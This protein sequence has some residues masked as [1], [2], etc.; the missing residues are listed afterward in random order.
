MILANLELKAAINRNGLHVSE[1]IGIFMNQVRETQHMTGFGTMK[2]RYTLWRF[3]IQP[4]FQDAIETSKT[5]RKEYTYAEI[6]SLLS[7]YIIAN[8]HV[9]YDERNSRIIHSKG[10]K[11]GVAFRVNS[12]HGSQV[13]HLIETQLLP[14]TLKE[15]AAH[16]IVKTMITV[17]YPSYNGRIHNRFHK[18]VIL[19]MKRKIKQLEIPETVEDFLLDF[20]NGM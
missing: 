3:H 19:T 13:A 5:N 12:F 14:S 8:K 20:F 4:N 2:E 15:L 6:L 7:R 18:N 17:T 1:L 11:L 9:L 10:T 16:K